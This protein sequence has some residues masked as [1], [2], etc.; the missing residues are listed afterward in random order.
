ME[1]NPSNILLNDQ[2]DP[3]VAKLCDFGCAHFLQSTL[4]TRTG[5]PFFMA[6]EIEPNNV[7]SCDPFRADV[8][9]FGVTLWLLINPF[10]NCQ[11]LQQCKWSGLQH[12]LTAICELGQR[13]TN[14]HPGERPSMREVYCI[15]QRFNASNSSPSDAARER[16]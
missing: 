1:V 15:L 4:K 10:A 2:E 13:C 8:Y 6:P 3:T 14:Q 16:D 7:K 5:T 12:V 11:Q 9:S